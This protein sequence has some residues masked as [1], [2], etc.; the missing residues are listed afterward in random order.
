[1]CSAWNCG[2]SD[3][4]SADRMTFVKRFIGELASDGPGGI[5][6]TDDLLKSV[7]FPWLFFLT[8]ATVLAVLTPLG[9]GFD[10]PWHFD[11]VQHVAQTGRVPLGHSE[12]LSTELDAFL[13]NHPQSWMVEK[14]AP[15]LLS[16]DEYWREDSR[17]RDFQDRVLGELRFSGKY[18]EQPPLVQYEHNQPPLYYVLTAPVFAVASRFSSVP[19]TFI[20]TRLWS[21]L[22]ASFVIPAA[23]L[24]ALAV[25]SN[26]AAAN[27]VAFLV[28]L[29]PGLYTGVVRV[30]NDALT[31]PLAC[32]VFVFLTAFLKTG[33]PLYFRALC[34]G[35]IAGLWTKAFF[36]PILAGALVALFGHLKWKHGLVLWGVALLGCPWYVYNFAYTGSWTG[37]SETVRAKTSVVSSLG[38]LAQMDWMNVLTSAR[39]LHIWIGNWSFLDVRTWMYQAVTWLFVL[40]AAGLLEGLRR[41]KK[42]RLAPVLAA[43]A[44]FLAGVAYH[45]TQAFQADGISTAAGWYLTSAIPLEA[46]IFVAGAEMWPRRY[47]KW[48]IL[49]MAVFEVALLA[50]T[51]MFVE[52]PYYSG[53]TSHGPSGSLMAYH[54]SRGDFGMMSVRLLRFT[55]FVPPF[56]P[57]LIFPVAIAFALFYVKTLY[58]ELSV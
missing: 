24:L 27:A 25:F 20:I 55:P 23:F 47:G 6:H 15:F 56:L 16:H 1:M 45:A 18:V 21:V 28:A 35:M 53:F 44:A 13:R 10:E 12:Y 50:Y 52:V 51:T 30:A 37:L 49:T 5:G 32:L 48:F 29:F 41:R 36:V 22:L 14:T 54:P 4:E 38:V 17:Q 58:H 9:E 8:F 42:W 57:W 7:L 33:N 3:I 43:Y 11:Y 39:K 34:V 26:V 31:V 19:H 40:G 46:V 2:E